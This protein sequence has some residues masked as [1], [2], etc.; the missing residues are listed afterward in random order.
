MEWEFEASGPIEAHIGVPAGVIDVVDAGSGKVTVQVEALRSG[1]RGEETAAN[2]DVSFTGGA[3][4]IK[5][6]DRHGRAA[7]VRCTVSLPEGSALTTQT[8]S[9]DVRCAVRLGRFS[10]TTASG[11]LV[12]GDVDA[13]VSVKAASGDLHCEEVGG[14][15]QA[16]TA[17]GDVWVARAGGDVRVT[18]ASGDLDLADAAA[19]VKVETASGDVTVGRVST[20]KIQVTSASGDVTV[21]VAPGVGAYLDV[22]TVTGDTT[23]TLPFTEGGGGVELEIVCRTVSGDVSIGKAAS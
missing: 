22:T 21:R 10:G 7:D 3:L 17:S 23:T 19:S 15:L 6:P 4:W 12:L 16:R 13:D 1:R 18:T 11:D 20:G 14:A 8:A 9:A 5:V 2:T